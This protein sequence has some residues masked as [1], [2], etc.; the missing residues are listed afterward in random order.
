MKASRVGEQIARIELFI[1]GVIRRVCRELFRL[2]PGYATVSSSRLRV[3]K[4]FR[5]VPRLRENRVFDDIASE[6]GDTVLREL[7]AARVR[8]AETPFIFELVPAYSGV[9][10]DVM[11]ITPIFPA[12]RDGYILER[13][14][15]SFL[16]E[17]AN[18]VKVVLQVL[19]CSLRALRLLLIGQVYFVIL[20][21]KIRVHEP[22]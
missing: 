7:E 16:A 4:V 21:S 15:S 5:G 11:M 12:L 20:G 18:A 6:P 2:F 13:L 22:G 8:I 14:E 1:L 9:D 3:D 17:A 10:C 19:F